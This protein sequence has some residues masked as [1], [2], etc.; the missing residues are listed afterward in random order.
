MVMPGVGTVPVIP[1]ICKA[2]VV[3]IFCR[4]RSGMTVMVHTVVLA[5]LEG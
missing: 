5:V 1:A 3:I 2:V 4:L